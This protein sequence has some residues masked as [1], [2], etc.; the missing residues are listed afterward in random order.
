MMGLAGPLVAVSSNL[1]SRRKPLKR[2]SSE[3]SRRA[4]SKVWRGS[5]GRKGQ[6]EGIL[7]RRCESA[8]RG[9]SVFV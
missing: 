1:G 2:A 9:K 7:T 6:A 3:R 5:R 4:P 8:R